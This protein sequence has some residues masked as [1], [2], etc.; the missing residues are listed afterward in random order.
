MRQS[1]ERRMERADTVSWVKSL[2]WVLKV[3]V[4]NS[5]KP[6]LITAQRPGVIRS[7]L[8]GILSIK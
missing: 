6:R 3:S 1:Q 4:G 7:A 5:K 8:R 2:M